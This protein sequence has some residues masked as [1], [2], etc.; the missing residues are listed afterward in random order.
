MRSDDVLLQ[1]DIAG[2]A[3]Q[4]ISWTASLRPKQSLSSLLLFSVPLLVP[5]TGLVIQS[6]RHRG[7]LVSIE[8]KLTTGT[9]NA[10]ISRLRLARS[11]LLGLQLITSIWSAIYWRVGAWGSIEHAYWL[12]TLLYSLAGLRKGKHQSYVTFLCVFPLLDSLKETILPL[13]RLPTK[14]TSSER[15]LSF[16]LQVAL[17]LV[18]L[19]TPRTWTPIDPT[20]RDDIASPEQTCTPFSYFVSY[21]WIEYLIRIA[22]HRD[23]VTDDLPPIPDYDRAR[24]WRNRI[25]EARRDSLLW[26]LLVL[27]RWELLMMSSLA[28]LVSL[29]QFVSPLAMQQLLQYLETTEQASINPYLWAVLLLL[30]PLSWAVSREMY[31]FVSTRMTIRVKAALT[32][33][34]YMKVMIMKANDGNEETSTG[35]V[36]NLMSTDIEMITLARELFLLIVQLPLCTLVSLFLLYSLMGHAALVG[37]AVLLLTLPVPGFLAAYMAFYQRAASLATDMRL[38]AISENLNSIRITKLF[39]WEESKIEIINALRRD[40]QRKLWLRNFV[41]IM[42]GIVTD[43]LP[44]ISM[45]ATFFVFTLLMNRPLLASTAFTSI[46]YFEI[47]RSQFLW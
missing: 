26:T 17:I 34:I 36:S 19:C 33:L 7:D 44:S 3:H 31:M 10:T 46:S 22:V 30:G 6:L 29:T 11:L 2:V 8:D 1:N 47:L 25:L 21:S 9:S 42:I 41:A 12:A 45:F 32:Q 39:G 37:F 40:E 38:S 43:I 5:L 16:V 27:M 20:N 28:V 18:P 23:I 15:Y 14:F 35:K 13:V 24:I 4:Q